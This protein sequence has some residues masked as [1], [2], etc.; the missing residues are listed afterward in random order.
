MDNYGIEVF[1]GELS[2]I[3]SSFTGTTQSALFSNIYQKDLQEV[4]GA[5]IAVYGDSK[6]EIT[7][8]Q[9][10]RGRGTNGGC[11]ALFGSIDTTI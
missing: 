5:F 10:A 1:S 8:T 11:I 2:V 7:D 3:N 9:F 4:N 6:L